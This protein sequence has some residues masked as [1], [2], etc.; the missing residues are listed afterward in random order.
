MILMR[1]KN[2]I[3]IAMIFIVSLL[4]ISA[5]SAADDAAS[6]IIADTDTNDVAVLEES[7]DDDVISDSQSGENVL[8][9]DPVQSKTFTDLDNLIK[10]GENEIELESDYNYTE[11]DNLQDGISINHDLTINGNGHT[12][13][14]NNQA[15]IFHVIDN[16]VVTFNNITFVNAYAYGGYGAAIWAE[17][18]TSTTSISCSFINNSADVGGA[19]WRVNSEN[20]IFIKNHAYQDGGAMFRGSAINC[21]FLSNSAYFNGNHVYGT[22]TENCIFADS[23]TLDVDDLITM[24]YSGEKQFINLT[25]ADGQILNNIP[26]TVKIFKNDELIGTYSALSGDAWVVNLGIGNYIAIFSVDANVEE[27]TRNIKIPS[28]TSFW[29]LDDIINNKYS[30]NAT[31]N[32][33]TDYIYEDNDGEDFKDGIKIVRDLT[34]NGNGHT[35][36]GKGM[37]RI[38]HVLGESVVTFNNLTFING[39]T[40]YWGYGGAISAEEISTVKAIN[41]IFAQNSATYGGAVSRVGCENCIFLSNKAQEFG[42]AMAY[43]N[44]SNCRFLLNSANDAIAKDIYQTDNENCIFAYSATLSVNDFATGYCSGEKQMIILTSEQGEALSNVP[45]TVKITKDGDEI[46][47]YSGL[48]GDGWAVNLS[49]GNYDAEF[50]VDYTDVEK[51]TCEISVATETSFMSLD[52]VINKMYLNNTTIYLDNDY[53][54]IEDS[55]SGLINGIEIVRNLTIDGNNHKINGSDLA[56]IF[57]VKDLAVVTFKNIAF[58]NGY[59][60][61]EGNGGAIWEEN[62]TVKAI[63]CNFTNNRAHSGGA[64]ANADAEDC[65][66]YYNIVNE[67]FMSSG[68]AIYNG[69]AVNCIFVGNEA[70]IFQ[71]GAIY[72]GNATGCNFTANKAHE[73]GAI[74]F[75]NATDCNFEGNEAA[76]YGGAIYGG[77]AI[78][79]NFTLNTAGIGG[80]ALTDCYALNCSFTGNNAINEYGTAMRGDRAYP[81]HA[82]NCIFTSNNPDKEVIYYVVADSC[83]FKGG[84]APGDEVEVYQPILTVNNFISTYNDGSVLVFNLTSKSG[85]PID[86]NIKIDV[87]TIDGTFVG[88]YNITGG[89]WKVPLNAGFYFATFNATEYDNV[90]VQRAILVNK[91]NSTIKSSD[92]STIY[93]EDKYLVV[94]LTDV[95]GMALSG[96]ELTITLDT[97]KN[98]TT[99]EKGQVK[100]NVANLLPKT[101]EAYISFAGNENYLPSSSTAKVTV[102]KISTSITASGVTTI[103]NKNKYLVIKLVDGKGKALSGVKVKVTLG[104]VKTYTTDKNGQIKINIAKLVPKTYNAKI[105]FAGNATYA[106]SS[107][108]V[109]VIVKKAS[110]KMTAKKKTFRVKVKTKKYTITLKNN[111]NKVMKNTKVTLKVNKKTFTA[112]TNKKGVATF[113]IT[114]L[115]KKGKFTAVIKYAGNKYYNKLSKKAIITVKK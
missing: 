113:K 83:I 7:I 101:Y 6:D 21:T 89:E 45:I 73:G 61:G 107:K 15:R 106:A 31:I 86:S 108:S 4:C 49:S 79:C 65:C 114:N 62:S 51:R 88:T 3:F 39:F 95:N 36:D 43:G 18:T 66:F 57:H 26:V 34:I 13:D 42:G 2:F 60:A 81:S 104:S 23:A 44:A 82:V 100:I 40:E 90:V 69:N 72:I 97:V 93:N 25:A 77:E 78:R 84:D 48:S 111:L 28:G 1:N 35:I 112:K 50:S 37:A 67:N 14:G 58:T 10:N 96:V 59:A 22:D 19:V 9:D 105:S 54:F 5:V 46:G 75:G 41:C 92:V 109:K 20:C 33:D 55:D 16:A 32:L 12:I 76:D 103:Y 110:V 115:K 87:E 80:G 52:C 47:T 56:R 98:Y 71:G 91:D 99:D 17:N 27:V 70:N 38:F 8:T 74:G 30:D 11:E 63:K 64:I 68:G 53:N 29:D 102:N 94:N 85:V 24:P